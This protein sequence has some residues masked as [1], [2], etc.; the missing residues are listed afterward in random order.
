M[1]Q[2][3]SMTIT[4]TTTRRRIKR[5]RSCSQSPG[6]NDL[7]DNIFAEVAAF[8]PKPSRALLAVAMIAP[9]SEWRVSK[10]GRPLS[11]TSRAILSL[12]FPLSRHHHLRGERQQ[13][14][15]PWL[16][17]DFA[18]L[19]EDLRTQLDDDDIRAILICINAN[20]TLKV[21]KLTGC[22]N[23]IGHG[24]EPLRRS[25]ALEQIDL[26]LVPQYES[27]IV[28][29]IPAISEDAIVPILDSIVGTPGN[30]LK[31][32]QLPKKFREEGGER[33][34]ALYEF[35]EMYARLLERRLATCSKCARVLNRNRG[36]ERGW[37]HK[38]CNSPWYGLQNYTCYQCT[39]HFCYSCA[40][41]DDNG[42]IL[43]WCLNCEKEYCATCVLSFECVGCSA[44]ICNGCK[45]L[46]NCARCGRAC[47][48]DCLYECKACHRTGCGDCINYLQ[49]WGR[50]CQKAHCEDCFDDKD[51]N[52]S[53]CTSCGA[54]FCPDCL[55]AACIEDWET[56]C[57]GCAERLAQ[58][59]VPL[60]KETKYI[61][62]KP[63]QKDQDSQ[64]GV[65]TPAL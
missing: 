15:G 59:V 10:R 12:S 42:D 35:L 53:L 40:D 50:Y 14:D 27:P 17:L 2:D 24:L 33:S 45:A 62:Q 36:S 49:C 25:I 61:K 11:A 31:Q 60:S 30:S 43:R 20:K 44:N 6:I 55:S 46:R 8:L 9:S 56:A 52:V 7:P 19:E 57:S 64:R 34:L 22:V 4:T 41:E 23:V 37:L 5:R 65:K 32:I 51:L 47:C 29:P 26:S 3:T 21:L 54:C 38:N 28:E 18:D 48:K 63:N 39:K 16:D 58:R 13:S 1:T